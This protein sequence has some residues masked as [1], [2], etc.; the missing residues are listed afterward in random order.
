MKQ[1]FNL[2]HHRL[3]KSR[4]N[5]LPITLKSKSPTVT[6]KPAA[7][8]FKRPSFS[9]LKFLYQE[10]YISLKDYLAAC[11]Y[12]ELSNIIRKIS[13]CPK[14]F[15]YKVSWHNY[16]EHSY[17]SWIQSDLC[18]LEQNHFSSCSD[19]EMLK[20][21]KTLQHVLNSLPREWRDK[22]NEL[23]FEERIP[24][25]QDHL[26]VYVKAFQKAMP[27][28]KSFIIAFWKQKSPH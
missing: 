27:E 28:I 11:K 4:V 21:W 2:K 6:E 3:R 25:F 17:I 22:F 20:L 16:I 13:G 14:G 12:V 23:V 24:K 5:L 26:R 15:N 18:L 7:S 19:D 8:T 1:A 9:C 10:E